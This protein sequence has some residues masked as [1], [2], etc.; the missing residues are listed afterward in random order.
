MHR[1]LIVIVLVVLAAAGGLYLWWGRTEAPNYRFAQ[2]ETGDLVTKVSASGTVNP[3]AKVEVGS[4]V[5]GLI[6][7]LYVDYNSEVKKGQIIAQIDPEPFELR[8][9]QAS[10]DLD[11]AR[12]SVVSQK[13]SYETQKIEV[14]RVK[15]QLDEARR[16]LERK[17]ALKDKKF[18]SAAEFDTVKTAFQ[19]TSRQYASAQSQL[20]LIGNQIATAEAT[21]RQRQ[22]AL[23]IAQTDLSHTVIRSPV[24]GIVVTR[25]IEAGQTVAASFQAPKLFEIA[26]NL[27]EMQVETD[28]D[29]AD[30]GRLKPGQTAV[31]TVDAYLNRPFTGMVRQIRK[32][33]TVTQNVT[34]YTV[35]ITASNPEQVLLPGMTA[36]VK[37]L[38]EQ[39]QNVLMVPNAALRF[40]PPEDQINK[41]QKSKDAEKPVA[42][43]RLAD[44][45]YQQFITL[46]SQL[47]IDSTT[48]TKIMQILEAFKTKASRLAN[49]IQGEQQQK[50]AEMVDDTALQIASRLPESQLP[51]YQSLS[52]KIVEAASKEKGTFGQLWVLDD[53][54]LKSIRVRTGLT[55][56][57]MT[58]VSGKDVKAG[59]PIITGVERIDSNGGRKSRGGNHPPPR[60]MR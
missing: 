49:L 32:S 47:D 28:V 22:A 11:S 4:Q 56:G 6:K 29:E 1:K 30:V 54:Q 31:F 57:T 41:A 34:T 35:L 40:R 10:A 15:L 21:V 23:Q 12:A 14:D 18:I 50:L 13:I 16:D 9:R 25:A 27:E 20:R 26:E 59:M 45:R 44:R 53:G 39:H 38:T 43:Q 60:M 7:S 33:P 24:N 8:V 55:D 19:T 2:I 58:E 36:D 48:R 51:K 3:V 17:R 42:V 46:V 5:S 52:A 37:I